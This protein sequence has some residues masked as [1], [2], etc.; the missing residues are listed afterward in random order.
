MKTKILAF[1]LPQ[2]HEIPENNRAWGNGFTEWVN[3]RK[4][5]PLFWGHNQPRVPYNNNYYNLLDDNIMVEQMHMAKEYGIYGFCF[6]HYWFN[7]KK[8]LEKP[9]EN[10]LKNPKADLPY[11]FAWANEAWT[12]T[13]HGAK[14]EKEVLL[15]QTYGTEKNWKEHYVYLR[16]FFL[17]TN[18]IKIDNKPVLLIYKVN[19][20]RHRSEMFEAFNLWAKEDGLNGIFI[21]QMLSDAEPK[22]K[23]KWING[24][25]DFEPAHIRNIMRENRGEQYHKKMEMID[26]HPKWRWWNRWVCDILDYNEINQKM[27]ESIH[28]KNHFRGCFVDYDDSPRRGKKALIFRGANPQQFAYYLKKQLLKSEEEGNEY[29]FVNAWNEWGE[30]NHLEPDEHFKY[31][32]LEEIA[33]IVKG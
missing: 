9:V 29:L 3:V 18:Y 27:L 13:W 21:V 17:D 19:N 22:S 33:K 4:A 26:R 11:C 16:D 7:G 30:G 2:F 1:Y 6:Y 20:M 32:Y 14:G 23:L 8:V 31:K 10:M 5:K 12:K 28:G 15:R 24:F 25:V